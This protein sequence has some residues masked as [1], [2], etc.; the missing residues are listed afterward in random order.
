MRNASRHQRYLTFNAHFRVVLLGA[1]LATL[2]TACAATPTS[3][4]ALGGRLC[5]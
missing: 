1:A 5:R 2:A 3:A 4:K